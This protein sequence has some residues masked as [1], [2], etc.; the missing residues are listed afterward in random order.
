MR[1]SDEQF[2]SSTLGPFHNSLG[3]RFF[4]TFLIALILG[5]VGLWLRPTLARQKLRAEVERLGGYCS[6]TF[7]FVSF[8]D[9]PLSDEDL[10][11]LIP[12][13]RTDPDLMLLD[14]QGTKITDA[15]IDDLKTLSHSLQINLENTA[16]SEAGRL[17]IHGKP[18]TSEQAERWKRLLKEIR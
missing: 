3:S 2:R 1:A 18:L 6:N 9:A 8:G 5:G 7:L 15:I 4:A 13:L 16:V 17:R 12:L 10:R 14:L 11:Q